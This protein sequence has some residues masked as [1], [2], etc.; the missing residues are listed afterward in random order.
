V[1]ISTAAQSPSR[2]AT[3][4]SRCQI[5]TI[6]PCMPDRPPG[7][8]VGPR[9]PTGFRR[10]IKVGAWTKF[11]QGATDAERRSAS[12]MIGSVMSRAVAP[13]ACSG[14]AATTR[15]RAR[16]CMNLM[17]GLGG[18]LEK[19]IAS[20]WAGTHISYRG[21][22]GCVAD[23]T[24][25]MPSPTSTGCIPTPRGTRERSGGSL[26]AVAHEAL[27]ATDFSKWPWQRTGCRRSDL[28]RR[29]DLGVRLTTRRVDALRGL[30]TTDTLVECDPQVS[31]ARTVKIILRSAGEGGAVPSAQGCLD[32]RRRSS[33]H[34]VS[35]AGPR[36]RSWSH[37]HI[38][39]P[40]PYRPSSSTVI[41]ARSAGVSGH[42]KILSGGQFSPR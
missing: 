26:S 18:G 17:C 41:K 15:R 20:V 29:G 3:C 10:L 24:I 31:P 8:N 12:D 21:K 39:A 32:L 33:S 40:H 4:R 36:T 9:G 25:L 38:S 6:S 30:A 14:K 1:R 22:A 7:Y 34:Q 13:P 16:C 23:P 28:C 11:A 42:V 2:L 27:L 5:L 37:S 35:S 19:R